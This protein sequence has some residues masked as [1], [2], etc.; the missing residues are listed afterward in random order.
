MYNIFKDKDYFFYKIQNQ[1]IPK[2]ILSR[3]FLRAQLIIIIIWTSA[4]T[5]PM[6]GRLS[7]EYYYIKF[8]KI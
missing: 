7:A 3:L 5:F 6:L 1:E 2:A 8:L 4:T